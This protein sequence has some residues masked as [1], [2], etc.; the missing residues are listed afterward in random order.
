MTSSRSAE[1][2]ADFF[3]P[4]LTPGTSIVDVGCGTGELSLELASAVGRLTGVD[5][6]PGD[7]AQARAAAGSMRDVQFLVGDAYALPLPDRSADAAFGH[8]V[9]EALD[10]PADALKEMRRV[11]KPGGVIGVAS[12]EYGGLVLGGPHV[13]LVRHFY[14]IREQ[15]WLEEG[16]D[17]YLGRRLR[18]LLLGQGFARVEASTRAISYG[19]AGTVREFGLGRADDCRDDWYV[20]SAQRLGLATRQEL[21]RMHDAWLDWSESPESYAAFTWCRAV[22]FND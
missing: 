13:Q 21:A 15:L 1:V 20:E 10:R 4:L 3:L 5:A 11:L 22:G 9:L 7:I 14:E 8:S 6:D 17:P 2:Y 18:G 12:V 16:A 19:T